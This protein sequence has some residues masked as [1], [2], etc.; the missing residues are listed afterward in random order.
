MAGGDVRSFSIPDS[1]VVLF[2]KVLV[3][4]SELFSVAADLETGL[5][6]GLTTGVSTAETSFFATTL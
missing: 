1:A 2:F 4:F 3:L 5:I 6:E